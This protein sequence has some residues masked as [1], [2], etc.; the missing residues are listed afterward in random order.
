MARW[1]AVELL[2]SM[3]NFGLEV[4]APRRDWFGAE[5]LP[6][7]RVPASSK[8]NAIDDLDHLFA[9]TKD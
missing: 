9:P 3:K 4:Y 1:K 6:L 8:E 2:T 7:L 5:S